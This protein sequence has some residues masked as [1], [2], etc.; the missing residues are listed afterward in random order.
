MTVD[1]ASEAW[2]RI[3]TEEERRAQFPSGTRLGNYDF[4]FVP[5]MG[6]L[7]AAHDRIGPAFSALI[8]EIMHNSEFLS[9]QECETVAAVT[10]AAQDC[11]Y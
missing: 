5:A 1:K 2:I 9:R 7:L 11:H 6:R 3:P 8:K 10:A 4:G